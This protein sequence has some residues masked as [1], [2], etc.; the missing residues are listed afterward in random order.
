MKD[1]VSVS[2]AAK[3]LY[4]SERT[5]WSWIR[6]DY[7]PFEKDSITGNVAISLQA[8]K[9]S[10]AYKNHM[11]KEINPEIWLTID[12]AVALTGWHRAIIFRKKKAGLVATTKRGK[13]VYAKKTDLER[14]LKN[15]RH[16]TE[17]K[18]I[19]SCCGLRPVAKGFRMLCRV[20]YNLDRSMIE[21]EAYN[22]RI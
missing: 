15:E 8:I 2:R 6:R 3:L 20:C 21:D 10:S 19:C 7:V 18:R 4:V 14:E 16:S 9:D 12:Q 13:N 17:K 5:I 22:V 11:P 1:T